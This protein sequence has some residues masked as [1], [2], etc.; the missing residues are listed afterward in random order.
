MFCTGGIRCEKSTAYLKQQGFDEVYHL[1]GGILK[2]LEEVP[3]SETR[4]QGECFVFDNRVTVNHKLERGNYDQC[5]ACRMPITEEDKSSDTYKQGVSCPHCYDR[6]SPEQVKR[7]AER[8]RQMEL[9]RKRGEQHIGQAMQTTIE[10]RKR[11][12]L[13][14]KERQRAVNQKS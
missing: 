13:R 9:A 5:H 7:Y 12:K 14:F 11:Q 1:K 8:E 4:W 10:Q 6:H 3:E 2:Y